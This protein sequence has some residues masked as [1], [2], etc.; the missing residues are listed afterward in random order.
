MNGYRFFLTI[1]DDFSRYTWIFLM[2][3]KFDV[4]ANVIRFISYVQNQFKTSIK[5]Y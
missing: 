5:K 2:L 1:V 3:N 4:R